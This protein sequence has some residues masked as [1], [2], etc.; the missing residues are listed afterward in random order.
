MSMIVSPRSLNGIVWNVNRM[1]YPGHHAT[2]FKQKAG[3]ESWNNRQLVDTEKG[4]VCFVASRMLHAAMVCQRT[5]LSTS[6]IQKKVQQNISHVSHFLVFQLLTMENCRSISEDP[7]DAIIRNLQSNDDKSLKFLAMQRLPSLVTRE[8]KSSLP[9]QRLLKALSVN[10]TVESLELWLPEYDTDSFDSAVD[11]KYLL[12]LLTEMLAK[13]QTIRRLTILPSVT[14]SAW[15]AIMTGLQVNHMVSQLFIEDSLPTCCSLYF[16]S[17]DSIASISINR[18]WMITPTNTSTHVVKKFF[19]DFRLLKPL[20]CLEVNNF[21]T[22]HI[23]VALEA[24]NDHPLISTLELINCDLSTLRSFPLLP[25]LTHVRLIDCQLTEGS[26]LAICKSLSSTKDSLE[27]LDLRGNTVLSLHPACCILHGFVL[28]S[29]TNL[30]KLIL[31]LCN[32]D[33]IGLDLLCGSGLHSN[34]HSISLR[35]NKLSNC[36][37]WSGKFIC[38]EIYDVDLCDNPIGQNGDAFDRCMRILV[39]SVKRLQLESCHLSSKSI[40]QLCLILRERSCQIRD[41][42]LSHNEAVGEVVFL[43]AKLL[44]RSR[45]LDNDGAGLER[46]ALSSCRISDTFL[47]TLCSAFIASYSS[48]ALDE[49]ILSGNEISNTGIA[50]LA[51]MLERVPNSLTRVDLQSNPFDKAGLETLAKCIGRSSFNLTDVRLSLCSKHDVPVRAKLHHWLLLNRAGRSK[52]TSVYVNQI[53]GSAVDWPS[54]LAVADEVYSLEAIYCL[55]RQCPWI[56]SRR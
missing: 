10:S 42:N 28:S 15:N 54:A 33:D 40:E 47:E 4:K 6:S 18:Y 20:R 53:N 48:L 21:E 50:H 2:I 9:T 17:N 52:I 26:L 11:S 41:L 29:C 5:K 14:D 7:I 8:K 16:A 49:L 44:F 38:S 31:D 3:L 34:I 37:V 27:L 12:S 46:L 36:D 51:M 43:I 30:G 32:I 19:S 55:I 13:N 39:R 45:R 1:K 56:L 22:D 24:L 23:T 35:E 25:S